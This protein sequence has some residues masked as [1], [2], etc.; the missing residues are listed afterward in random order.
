MA[1]PPKN[2]EYTSLNTSTSIVIG[3]THEALQDVETDKESVVLTRE[4]MIAQI[5]ELGKSKVILVL[6]I[7]IF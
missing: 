6:L 1:E 7:L 3:Q 2:T 4:Q 5:L